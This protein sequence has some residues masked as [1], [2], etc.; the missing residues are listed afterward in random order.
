MI[1]CWS[2]ACYSKLAAWLMQMHVKACCRSSAVTDALSTG[3]S[4]TV[5]GSVA[6]GTTIEDDPAAGS[7][8]RRAVYSRPAGQTAPR[9]AAPGNP[10]VWHSATAGTA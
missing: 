2:G 5:G 7:D 3:I 8:G 9:G 4:L 1:V 10:S 6:S